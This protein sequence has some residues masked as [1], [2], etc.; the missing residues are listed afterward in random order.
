[1]KLNKLLSAAAAGFIILSAVPSAA[2]A[3]DDTMLNPQEELTD[4]TFTYEL[5]N[6]SY[7]LTHCETGAIVTEVPQERNGYTITAIAD[8]AF[9]ECTKITELKIPMSVKKIGTSAFAGCTSLS[10]ITL[11]DKLTEIPEGAFISCTSLESVDIP[12]SVTSIGNYA[13]YGCAALADVTLPASLSNFGTMAFADCESIDNIDASKCSGYNFAD[14]MLTDSGKTKIYRA[15]TKLTGDVYIDNTVTSIEPGAFSLCENIEN[16][17]IPS[18]VVT[19][20]DD[21]FGYCGGLKKIDFSEGLNT[22]AP[23][24]FK[25]CLELET[26]EFPTTL[27]EIGEGAF[28]NCPKLNRVTL[29]EGLE[30][31]G[32]GAFVGCTSLNSIAVP[33][34]VTKI[35]ENAFGYNISQEGQY[36]L[37]NNFKMSVFSNTAGARYAFS[38][39]ISSDSV[40]KDLKKTAFLIV[41]AGLVIA[42]I[43]F[44]IVLM[45][46]GRK[47][48]S[49]A[50]KEAEK[51]EKE[52]EE[53]ANYKKI[54]DE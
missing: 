18:S 45:A 35:D 33:R 3:V 43:V 32:N 16:L 42:A 48:A 11:P 10:K 9:T 46:R 37:N 50:V 27:K 29:N 53:E 23:I 17:F 54:I 40:D 12:D 52:Q 31:V 39:K 8:N 44:A 19:I 47:G 51:L 5:E 4:G 13:F 7:I 22:I 30:T 14:G 1:M 24:A 36:E 20:G 21:A 25:Y 2:S 41:A 15:S 38:N 49:A 34:S 26:V 28:F 6:G